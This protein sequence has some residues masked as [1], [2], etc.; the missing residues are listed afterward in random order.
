M[1][2]KEDQDWFW[3]GAKGFV[4]FMGLSDGMLGDVRSMH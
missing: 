3:K 2:T 4:M 1:K